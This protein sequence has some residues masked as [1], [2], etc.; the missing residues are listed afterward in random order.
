VASKQPRNSVIDFAR[1]ALFWAAVI[2]C[3]VCEVAILRS[4]FAPQRS[5]R[6]SQS[7]IPHSP[8]G[9][10]ILWGVIP[11]IALTLLLAAT[12]RAIR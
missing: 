10:E 8:H 11:A 4:L 7:P 9:A 2:V 12:W 3:I 6:E 1:V 5:S